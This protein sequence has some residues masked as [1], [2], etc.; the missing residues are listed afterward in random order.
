MKKTRIV[1]VKDCGEFFCN[2]VWLVYVEYHLDLRW[3]NEKKEKM[4]D[5]TTKNRR[6]SW[7]TIILLLFFFGLF[8]VGKTPRF[9]S[10]GLLRYVEDNEDVG[11]GRY[12][13]EK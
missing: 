11:D 4:I 13:E 5:D 9:N 1:F 2:G 10:R 3:W 8:F 6:L 12:E 7:A